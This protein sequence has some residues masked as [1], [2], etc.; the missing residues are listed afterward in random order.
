MIFDNLIVAEVAGVACGFVLASYHDQDEVT[1][2]VRLLYRDYCLIEAIDHNNGH[3]AP[4]PDHN[5]ILEVG[6]MI[7]FESATD[8]RGY[9]VIQEWTTESH[10]MFTMRVCFSD[11]LRVMRGDEEVW[12]VMYDRRNG[13]LHTSVGK[14]PHELTDDLRLERL[15][16]DE[17]VETPCGDIMAIPSRW[18]ET[19]RHE[20]A[21]WVQLARGRVRAST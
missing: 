13:Q 20:A 4:R 11:S 19:P 8:E 2:P 17:V 18:V 21:K 3:W 10:Y 12:S 15:M 1:H 9:L 6:D 7:L 16:P 14:Q 5:T